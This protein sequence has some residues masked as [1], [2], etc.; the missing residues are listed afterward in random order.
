MIPPI[1]HGLEQHFGG[2]KLG[3]KILVPESGMGRLANDNRRSRYVYRTWLPQSLRTDNRAGYD[4]TANK[5]DYSSILAYHV[6]TNHTSSLH[7]HTLQPSVTKWAHQVNAESRYSVLT[8]LD[9]WPN[10]AVKLIE[11]DFWEV[12]PQDGEFDAVITTF[13]IDMSENLV[14]F[15]S[16]IH[17]LLKPGGVWINLGR[18]LLSSLALTLTYVLFP[19]I[20]Q[21]PGSS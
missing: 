8:V 16:N 3:K 12:F 19:M 10:K 17:R 21:S 2:N 14:D 4:V 5:L 11:G 9:H 18:T 6:L 13:F 1:L 15:L 20:L 7:Q